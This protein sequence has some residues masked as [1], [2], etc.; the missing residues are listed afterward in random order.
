MELALGVEIGPR[1]GTS[2]Q[3]ESYTFK[4]GE[5]E[6]LLNS[7]QFILTLLRDDQYK[8]YSTIAPFLFISRQS[9]IFV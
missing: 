7:K 2:P 3:S 5:Y 4:R 6:S 9:T 8:V 1:L